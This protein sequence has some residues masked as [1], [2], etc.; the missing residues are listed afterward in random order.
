MRLKST[1]Q[2]HRIYYE[3]FKNSESFF[4]TFVD[5]TSFLKPFGKKVRLRSNDEYLVVLLSKLFLSYFKTI[6]LKCGYVTEVSWFFLENRRL[7]FFTNSWK[8]LWLKFVNK[9][10]WFYFI[11]YTSFKN[12]NIRQFTSSL[13]SLDRLIF[14]LRST[15][16]LK[17]Y[18][19]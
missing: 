19:N 17:D 9:V 14:P 2:S 4:G 13:F 12:I 18:K 11:K 6:E 16:L 8:N 5:Q 1:S 3:N 7:I 15:I 10:E